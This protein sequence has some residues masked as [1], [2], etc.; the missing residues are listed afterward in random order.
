MDSQSGRSLLTSIFA[1][2]APSFD[3]IPT[4]VQLILPKLQKR[5]RFAA[6]ASGA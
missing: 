6:S 4:E 1:L 3:G 2:Q 5:D